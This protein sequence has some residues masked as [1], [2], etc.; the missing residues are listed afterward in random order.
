MSFW[1]KANDDQ[2]QLVKVAYSTRKPQSFKGMVAKPDLICVKCG[3]VQWKAMLH[4]KNT[5]NAKG[6][7]LLG[8]IRK[9]GEAW[10]A[11]GDTPQWG[12][13][14]LRKKARPEECVP[15]TDGEHKAALDAMIG[16]LRVMDELEQQIKELD[17]KHFDQCDKAIEDQ[18]A[19]LL[20]LRVAMD[21]ATRSANAARKK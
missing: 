13:K 5:V 15:L 19:L 14:G 7:K 18:E 2:H 12:T 17:E 11:R 20:P 4:E 1:V 3:G 16:R 6:R 21:K 10:A 9:V 8:R